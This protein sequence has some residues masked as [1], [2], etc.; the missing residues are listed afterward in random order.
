M[1]WNYSAVS[2]AGY[3]GINPIIHNT[4]ATLF[5]T[6]D[7]IFNKKREGTNTIYWRKYDFR[8]TKNKL[9]LFTTILIKWGI[10]NSWQTKWIFV[11]SLNQLQIS[12][13]SI[14][15]D[16]HIYIWW[17]LKKNHSNCEENKPKK[18]QLPLRQC[19]YL[20]T[21]NNWR[22]FKVREAFFALVMNSI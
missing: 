13:N 20:L 21:L 2:T 3:R 18:G 15:V 5:I 16:I 19:V 9:K 4:A 14:Y 7:E 8:K 10:C 11:N 6:Q 22:G 17:L 12:P 1:C